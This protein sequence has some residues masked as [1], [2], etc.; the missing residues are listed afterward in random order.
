[1]II[2]H[3]VV[4]RTHRTITSFTIHQKSPIWL[5]RSR[6]DDLTAKQSRL[7]EE[8]TSLNN[9]I[10]ELIPDPEESDKYYFEL[11]AKRALR[12]LEALVD[13]EALQAMAA[14]EG[15]EPRWAFQRLAA[16]A[17]S[18]FGEMPGKLLWRQAG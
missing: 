5:L 3:Q 14:E 12:R 2:K 13:V 10:S 9:R 6:S 18:V 15:S 11:T 16:I 4:T 1:M 17:P 7:F 8:K